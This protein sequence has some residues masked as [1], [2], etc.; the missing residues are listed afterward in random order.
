MDIVTIYD[1]EGACQQC[2]GWKRVDDGKQQSWKYWAELPAQ[3]AVA[4]RMG[5]VRPIE[6]PRCHGTGREPES[7]EDKARGLYQKFIRNS[8]FTRGENE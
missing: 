5:L 7:V 3:S 8:V 4:V 1:G 2:L 6:C